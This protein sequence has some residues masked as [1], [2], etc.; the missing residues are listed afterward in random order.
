M[1]RNERL[2]ELLREATPRMAVVSSRAWDT[3]VTELDIGLHPPLHPLPAPWEQEV[4]RF[5]AY[6]RITTGIQ[7]STGLPRRMVDT[8]SDPE[9][10]EILE[11]AEGSMEL[12]V[13]SHRLLGTILGGSP[14]VD[15]GLMAGRVIAFAFD[16]DDLHVVS[17]ERHGGLRGPKEKAFLAVSYWPGGS[18][19]CD[20]KGRATVRPGGGEDVAKEKSSRPLME[21]TASAASSYLLAQEGLTDDLRRLLESAA[22]GKYVQDGNDVTALL[23]DL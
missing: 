23:S 21:A 1:T 2:L 14:L 15:I 13:T 3:E 12:V 7:S 17:Y 18:V 10:A 19:F 8:G 16:Y 11:V 9:D 6:G 20:V 5:I 4:A 22:A